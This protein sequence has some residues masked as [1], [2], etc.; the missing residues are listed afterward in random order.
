MKHQR[1][2]RSFVSAGIAAALASGAGRRVV[3]AKPVGPVFGYPIREPGLLPGDGFI[4]RVGYACENAADY[5]GWW[6]TGEHFQRSCPDPDQRRRS[7]NAR[8]PRG[9]HG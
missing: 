5:P 3:R 7:A 2:R 4:I 9:V 8:Q 6:H 1:T